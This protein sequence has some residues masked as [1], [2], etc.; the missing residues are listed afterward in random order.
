MISVK[1]LA[2]AAAML[3]LTG[4]VE[5]LISIRSDPPGATVYVD[6][7]LQGK[8]PIDVRYT[9]YGGRDVTLEMPGFVS[10]TKRVDLSPPWWQY[11]P[12]DFVTD[13]LIPFTLTDRTELHF[14]MAT[15]TAKK[16]DVEGLK[17]RAEEMK[18][19]LGREGAKAA[20][21]E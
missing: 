2:A 21:D 13:L 19:K 8:T 1:G 11:V 20:K 17:A 5:R 6:G 18:Q 3:L 9:W 12:F 10:I 7:E 15:E 14:M 16:A 4:C